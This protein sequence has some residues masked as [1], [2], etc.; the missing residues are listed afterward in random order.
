VAQPLLELTLSRELVERVLGPPLYDPPGGDAAE[1]VALPG[2]AAG[3]VWTSVR[4]G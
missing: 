1:A 2:A 3:L 4:C